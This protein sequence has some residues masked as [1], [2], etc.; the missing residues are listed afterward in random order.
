MNQS[1]LEPDED[2][3]RAKFETAL[4]AV[5]DPQTA[6]SLILQ[7][8]GTHLKPHLEF[9]IF[10]EWTAA[11]KRAADKGGIP[12]SELSR[13]FCERAV[14][15]LNTFY[16]QV[17]D[18]DQEYGTQTSS[19][20]PE[21]EYQKLASENPQQ[22]KEPETAV[23][24]V[25]HRSSLTFAITTGLDCA[26]QIITRAGLDPTAALMVDP[27]CGEGKAVLIAAS[28]IFRNYVR[29]AEGSD[30]YEP[31]LEIAKNN[32]RA[33]RLRIDPAKIEFQ[34]AN[35]ATRKN[36]G[37]LNIIYIYNPFNDKI[38]RPFEQNVRLYGGRTVLNYNKPLYNQILLDAG[39]KQ[40][41]FIEHEDPDRRISI[42][43]WDLDR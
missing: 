26:H 13:N 10:N 1:Q 30:Y 5:T 12:E 29:K 41:H 3:N 39:W 20:I 4:N 18:F 32:A 34:F 9:L 36:Y 6:A 17:L 11:T 23:D 35:A 38:M 25:K 27:T 40:E 8:F 7:R 15:K 33:P 2:S 37:E 42:L 14:E 21:T 43:S 16:W 31:V 22:F 19:F 28:S 24:G